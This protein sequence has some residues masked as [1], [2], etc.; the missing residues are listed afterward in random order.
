MIYL[1]DPVF[2]EKVFYEDSLEGKDAKVREIMISSWTSFASFG[3]PTPSSEFSKFNWTTSIDFPLENYLDISGPEPKMK[4]FN[5]KIIKRMK[6][7]ETLE[8][9]N[10]Y[11]KT[12]KSL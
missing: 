11:F 5:D 4:Q 2:N 3:N 6:F 8:P 9:F 1:W 10:H 12:E 7:W